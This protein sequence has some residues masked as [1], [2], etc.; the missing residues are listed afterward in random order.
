VTYSAVSLYF[1]FIAGAVAPKQGYRCKK[2]NNIFNHT[3]F[4]LNCFLKNFKGNEQKNTV[5]KI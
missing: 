5:D 2:A 3:Y 1:L 4:V